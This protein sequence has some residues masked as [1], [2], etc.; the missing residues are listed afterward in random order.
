MT[1]IRIN[2]IYKKVFVV[3]EI[4]TKLFL[5]SILISLKLDSNHRIGSEKNLKKINRIYDQNK[6][7]KHKPSLAFSF[8]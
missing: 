4:A 1:Q 3:R 2:R 7:V 8:F 5:N 6:T